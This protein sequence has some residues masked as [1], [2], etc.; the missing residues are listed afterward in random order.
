M[1]SLMGLGIRAFLC[2]GVALLATA[3][4]ASAQSVSA[5]VSQS[6]DSEPS[7][8]SEIIVTANKREQR[9][10]DVA[11]AVTVVSPQSLTEQGE[12]KLTDYASRVPGLTIIDAS[13]GSESDQV[14]I[15]GVTTGGNNPTVSIYIDDIPLNAASPLALGSSIPDIDPADLRQIEVL[16]GPQGTL[17]GGGSIGGLI[18]YDTI[19]PVYNEL[20]ARAEIG[21][22]AVHDGGLGYAVRASANIPINDQLALRISGFDR[23]D[24]GYIDNLTTGQK[25][26]NVSHHNGGRVTLGWEINSKNTLEFTAFL[27]Q[28][29]ALANDF[30]TM[31]PTTN[32]PIGSRY[33][34]DTSAGT[35]FSKQ[36]LAVYAIRFQSDLDWATLVSSTSYTQRH[37]N[38]AFDLTPALGPVVEAV[39]GVSNAS[40]GVGDVVN[41]GKFTEEVRLNGTANKWLDWQVGAFYTHER[42]SIKQ[43]WFSGDI[44]TGAAFPPVSDLGTD[45]APSL[46]QQIAG[47]GD[48]TFHL[49]DRLSVTGGLRYSHDAV[50]ETDSSEGLFYGTSYSRFSSSDHDVTYLINPKYDFTQDV[51][52]YLRLST[53]FRPGGPNVAQDVP[54]SYG[55]DKTTNYEGGLK[56][57]F[58]AKRVTF[59]AAIFYIDWKDI[60]ITG[61]GPNSTSYV[62]NGG[63]AHSQG[64]EAS[65][66][67]RPVK[68]LS[69]AANA[70]YT[71]ARLDEA[72][73]QP[74]TTYAPSGARL[75]YSAR[76]AGRLD[77]DYRRS[78]IK[79]WDGS[80]GASYV[81][82]GDRF[83]SFAPDAVTPRYRLS[84]YGTLGLRAGIEN[85][86]YAV[87]LYVDNVTNK[88]AY[89]ST[90][91]ILERYNTP[92]TPRT[93]GLSLSA[94]Y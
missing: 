6:A 81:Y 2:S 20:S 54:K 46:F 39:F 21:G 60:Q 14:T 8:I 53:G 7:G 78:V 52:A 15:R 5:N 3:G 70:A 16:K 66:V 32:Q 9:L 42:S 77:V 75:P 41:T 64:I 1:R 85:A 29:H 24:P 51:S 87:H 63:K 34:T 49:T 76:F 40:A 67:Y 30:V 89:V 43:F 33:G 48:V 25:D 90:F 28:N 59:D 61:T 38:S 57:D 45:V 47:F 55:P 17:Y 10:Q 79:G 37:L 83:D 50:S 13:A 82:V 73:P 72:L 92:V 19:A 56:G 80:V 65:G 94:K 86:T 68:A 11:A 44:V 88:L 18:K 71:D 84:P 12:L 74:G 69:I 35:N 23:E 22:T 62:Y 58:F 31:S 26:A 91:P 36:S 27:D 4:S 93:A